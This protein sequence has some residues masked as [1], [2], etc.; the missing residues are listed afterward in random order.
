M[1]W[2]EQLRQRTP[3]IAFFKNKNETFPSMTVCAASLELP[4]ATIYQ[5]IIHGYKVKTISGDCF[6]DYLEESQGGTK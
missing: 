1:Q 4:E 2:Y 3:I 5:A 6:F